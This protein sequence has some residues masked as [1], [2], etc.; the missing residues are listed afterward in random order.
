MARPSLYETKIKP[1][2]EEIAEL[3]GQG[4][5]KAQIAAK[6]G[7]S[8]RTLYKYQREIEEF[9]K[10]ATAGRAPAVKTLEATAFK[11]ATG[12]YI[13]VKKVAKLIVKEYDAD[14][15]KLK[16]VREVLEPYEEEQ[17]YPP[18]NAM[19]IFLLKNWSDY[20]NDP[21]AA[22]ARLKELELKIA[23]AKANNFDLE[24]DK[25]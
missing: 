1:Y 22:A 7:I 13:T 9:K 23:V 5:P 15:G 12:Y 24:V 19:L 6:F 11:S 16:S 2:L 8:E 20:S 17:Y 21:Q 10:T 3:I 18:Q 25:I 14:S 4:I